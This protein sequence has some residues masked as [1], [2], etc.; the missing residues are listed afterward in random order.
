MMWR[1]CR[2]HRAGGTLGVYAGSKDMVGLSWQ[3]LLW[4]GTGDTE[5]GRTEDPAK[6]LG[7]TGV[8]GRKQTEKEPG[9]GK[10]QGCDKGLGVFCLDSIRS[11]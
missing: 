2:Q 3:G 9:C 7:A 5:R 4:T 10:H 6:E 8:K 1:H 11:S